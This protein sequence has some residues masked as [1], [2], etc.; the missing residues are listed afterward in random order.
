MWTC[1]QQLSLP[2][3]LRPVHV[4]SPVAP[5]WLQYSLPQ[6]APF[7]HPLPTDFGKSVGGEIIVLCL[8]NFAHVCKTPPTHVLDWAVDLILPI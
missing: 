5:R 6:A 2:V 4:V 7:F 8:R 3:F 1:E